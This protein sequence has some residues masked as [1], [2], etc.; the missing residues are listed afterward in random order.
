MAI[1][2]PGM[3]GVY[4]VVDR[5]QVIFM[6]SLQVGYRGRL[7]VIFL[8]STQLLGRHYFEGQDLG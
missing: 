8:S 4:R 5:M 1:S 2:H 3:D 7:S 6:E